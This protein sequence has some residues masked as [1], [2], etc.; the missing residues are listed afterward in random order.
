MKNM[1]KFC[2]VAW[3]VAALAGLAAFGTA[4]LVRAAESAAPA[5]AGGAAVVAKA[6]PSDALYYAV[7]L[8]VGLACLGAG[9]AV[10]KVGS[11]AMGVL[12]EKPELFG[13]VLIFVALAEGIAIYGVGVAVLLLFR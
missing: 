7:A 4:T 9:Y 5:A 8:T 3:G 10:A 2:S 13:R 1:R 6:A 12:S 11:A